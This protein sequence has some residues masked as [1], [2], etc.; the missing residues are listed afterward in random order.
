MV[1]FFG[2]FNLFRKESVL[3]QKRNQATFKIVTLEAFSE[4]INTK[5]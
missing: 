1:L 5:K 2:I 3:L 4:T